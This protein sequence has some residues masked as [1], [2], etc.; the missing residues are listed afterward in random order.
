M[1]KLLTG[2]IIYISFSCSA[3]ETIIPMY[4][5]AVIQQALAL[6]PSI[7]QKVLVNDTL[8]LPFVDDFSGTTIFPSA[9]KWEDKDVFINSDMARNMPTVGVATFDGLD[10]LGNPYVVGSS[11][12][13]QADF[14]TSLP[15]YLGAFTPSDNI[16]ISFFYQKKG[17]GDAPEAT[18]SLVLEFYDPVSQVWSKQWSKNGG[19]TSGQDT[20]FTYDSVII[21]NSAFLKD[22]FRFRF[23]SYGSLSGA[24]DNW[25]LDYVRVYSV[26]LNPSVIVDQ[27]FYDD[28]NALLNGFT[29]V[30]WK[31]YK[32]LSNQNTIVPDSSEFKYIVYHNQNSNIGL[33]HQTNDFNGDSVGGFS[34]G[35]LIPVV[36]NVRTIY[37]YPVN[38]I[39][40]VSPEITPYYSYFDV[41]DYFAGTQ[42]AAEVVHTNDTISHRQVFWNYYSMDD[43]TCEVGYDLINAAG[44]KVA[45]RID[46]L[47]PDT[48]RGVQ[49]FF[50]QQNADVSLKLITIKIWSSLSPENVVFQMPN[51]HPAYIDSINGFATYFFNAPVAAHSFY[52]GFQQVSPD[53]LHLGF[54]RN[55]SSNSQMY[56]N[57]SGTW[58][59]VSVLPG[60]FMIRPIVSDT[61]LS[62]GITEKETA[63]FFIYPNPSSDIININIPENLLF[64]S[65]VAITDVCGKIIYNK[66]LSR[67]INIS[68]LD[69]GIYFIKIIND[70]IDLPAKP[71]VI[72][73]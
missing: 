55:T 2:L 42:G 11:S 34:P 65:K 33:V 7:A 9:Q 44:G 41:I 51:Q 24:L 8:S 10:D 46:M 59:N 5:N 52:I 64:N 73:R 47:Q 69:N 58:S 29:S 3:Q 70:K 72:H 30:P 45:M 13:G 56:Y 50:T 35:S 49:I 57:T 60:T 31:H 28:K 1:K 18:D 21:N 71:I 12:A 38:Y 61:A 17:F 68:E 20:V 19:I 36:A 48:L 16:Y 4:H 23:H 66:T 63:D 14:L 62:T 53:G 22:G 15:F 25:H 26:V 6:N 67:S 37:K 54:D 27:A 32:N 39:Y 43:G 40:P